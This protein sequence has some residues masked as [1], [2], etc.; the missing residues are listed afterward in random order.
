LRYGDRILFDH[1]RPFHVARP[2]EIFLG[3]NGSDS[4]LSGQLFQG[5]I[6]HVES[7]A[8]PIS[9]VEEQ[10]G[11]GHGPIRLSLRFPPFHVA[12]GEP[13]LVC[14]ARGAADAF[15]V[16]YL[17]EG[18][19]RIGHDH[20]GHRG[21]LSPPVAIDYG[22]FHVVELNLGSLYP[23]PSDPAWGDVA[24]S[25]RHAARSRI[26][27]RLNGE[28]ILETQE[29]AYPVEPDQ[30]KI[31]QNGIGLSTCETAFTGKIS[32]QARLGLRP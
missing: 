18:H 1:L 31:G 17:D 28:I 8:T 9:R 7:L 10:I 24:E 4:S 30:I 20:W 25:A 15:Y 11:H 14:G 6:L 5:R 32:A 19:I 3:F 13:L 29:A 22:S 12:R 21:T 2:F 23:D 27:V 16:Q 26:S